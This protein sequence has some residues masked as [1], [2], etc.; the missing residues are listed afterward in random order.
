MPTYDYSCS[1]CSKD[2]EIIQKI[3][4]PA[5]TK[6]PECLSGNIKRGIGGGSA[7]LRFEGSGFYITDYGAS[8]VSPPP[9]AYCGC[10]KTSCNR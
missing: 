7:T 4:E 3:S 5:L 2:F 6:C 1:N 10:N 9:K 8:K